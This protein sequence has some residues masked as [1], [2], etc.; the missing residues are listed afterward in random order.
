MRV[1]KPPGILFWGRGLPDML[2]HAVRAAISDDAERLDYC[3]E[4]HLPT[5]YLV[6]L[7][8]GLPRSQDPIDFVIAIQAKE[9]SWPDVPSLGAVIE[10][11]EKMTLRMMS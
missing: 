7:D 11:V 1:R 2:P 10:A 3:V 5:A 4:S 6:D 9:F 8:D